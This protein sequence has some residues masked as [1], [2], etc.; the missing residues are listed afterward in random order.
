MGSFSSRARGRLPA[1]ALTQRLA[2]GSLAPRIHP[3]TVCFRSPAPPQLL[4]SRLRRR[5]PDGGGI[6]FTNP[7]AVAINDNGRATVY[8]SN[9]EARKGEA[10]KGL[11]FTFDIIL[12]VE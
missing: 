3:P 4:R 11:I 8:P 6:A 5:H 1:M 2:R 10:R 9:M 12:R 7:T